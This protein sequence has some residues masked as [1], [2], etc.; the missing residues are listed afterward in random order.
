MLSRALERLAQLTHIQPKRYAF[1][2]HIYFSIRLTTEL[3]RAD[4]LSTQGTLQAYQQK[5]H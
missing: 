2:I 3:A 4:A 1:G 5:E